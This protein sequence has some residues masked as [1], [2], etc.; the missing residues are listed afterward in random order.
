MAFRILGLGWLGQ[1]WYWLIA[2]SSFS[3]HLLS[4]KL[5]PM[6]APSTATKEV[7]ESL[8]AHDYSLYILLLYI[9]LNVTF[10]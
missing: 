4:L 7:A 1:I 8:A 9:L 2:K 3:F 5:G 10:M 6:I